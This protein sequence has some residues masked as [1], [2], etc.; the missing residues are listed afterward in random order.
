MTSG[1]YVTCAQ[2]GKKK[3]SKRDCSTYRGISLLSHTGKMYAKILE[4]R[5]QYKVEPL[6]S[7]AQMGFRKGRGRTDA[8][9]ALRPL[10][11][12]TI[13]YSK[14]LNLVSVDQEKAFDRVN[15]NKLWKTLEEYN[16]RGQLLDN[17]RAIYSN[18]MSAICTQDGLTE[19]FGVTSGVRQGCVLSPLLFSAYMD[20][21]T[22]EANPNPED[23]NEMLFAD[24]QSLVREKEGE[25]QEHTNSLNTQCESFDMKISI[26]KTE[27]MKVSRTPGRLNINIDGTTLKQV[28]EFKY[29][30]SIFT[31]DGRLN[32]E[33]ES[34][35][36]KTNSFGYQL[37]PLLRHPNIPIDIKAKLIESIFRPTLTYQ[38]QT[39]TL[40]K[41]LERKITTCEIRC[42]RRAAN[43]TRRDKVKN[44]KIREMV[45]TTPILHHIQQ[46]RIRWFGHLTRMAP[47][48]LGSKAYNT[49]I[50]GY[51][52][53][54]RLRKTWIEGV[55][56]TLKTHN[57]PPTQAFRLA[58]DRKL[59]L[60]STPR[61]VQED[62]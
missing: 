40:T 54:G 62:G 35:V 37:A 13:E 6:L 15:R 8:V 23:L 30:G 57:I 5:T 48:Q 52:A 34:T 16:V 55:K 32:R 24:D 33:I 36:Q 42:L 4:Q 19:W 12:K 9:F 60:P 44:T 50:S 31:E 1:G 29:L 18:S 58:G 7:E 2:S 61:M 10:S 11:E 53:R 46:Q 45:G 56:E 38:S 26:S 39:W 14:E 41:S 3:G 43:K 51:K 17:I 59:F 47:H 28:G 49:K 21:I 25:L 20:K 22:R 27:T